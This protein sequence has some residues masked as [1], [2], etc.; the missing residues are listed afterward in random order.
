MPAQ[1]IDLFGYQIRIQPS[2]AVLLLWT[3]NL[4]AFLAS[5]FTKWMK[6][7]LDWN[8]GSGGSEL[9]HKPRIDAGLLQNMGVS[10]N[11]GVSP[12]IMNL[13]R[14]FHYKPSILGYPKFLETTTSKISKMHSTSRVTSTFPSSFSCPKV[15]SS[16]KMESPL[17]WA[18]CAKAS[19]CSLVETGWNKRF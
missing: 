3:F 10:K 16:T 6:S 19:R 17:K 14:V 11:S 13:N 12:Q 5:C 4:L 18:T 2:L 8:W 1:K 7:T 15:K 9:I